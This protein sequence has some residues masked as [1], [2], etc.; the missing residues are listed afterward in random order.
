M[1]ILKTDDEKK[2]INAFVISCA[3]IVGY[4]SIRFIL[5]MGDWFDLESKIPYFVNSTHAT[6][7]ILGIAFL[8]F[9]KTNQKSA[10]YF[11]EVY[12]ELV[13]VI[14]PDKDSIF[15]LTIGILVAL[16]VVSG[17]LILVDYIFNFILNLI[18]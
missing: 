4:V 14:W 15:K 13:K 10:Q 5:Q 8:V 11:S 1:S 17:I 7:V 12:S 18:Y 9:I 2:W 6:G 3:V 16:V